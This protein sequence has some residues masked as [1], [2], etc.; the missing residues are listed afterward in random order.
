ML[1][2]RKWFHENS[3][4]IMDKNHEDVING[5]SRTFNGD[6]TAFQRC[7]NTGKVLGCKGNKN[8]YVVEFS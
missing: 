1:D 4:Y 2:I 3:V 5:P 8:V 6:E 7:P